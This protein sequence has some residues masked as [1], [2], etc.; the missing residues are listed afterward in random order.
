MTKEELRD[1][2]YSIGLIDTQLPFMS[3]GLYIKGYR[4]S[5]AFVNSMDFIAAFDDKC[6]NVLVAEDSVISF[7]FPDG[8]IR[9]TGSEIL[10][11]DTNIKNRINFLIDKVKKN[12]KTMKE[13]QLQSKL[14]KIEGDFK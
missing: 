12:I 13:E 10:Y 9:M 5:G 1:Y 11:D 14:S 4:Y 6:N 8:P 3:G 2:C 7:D